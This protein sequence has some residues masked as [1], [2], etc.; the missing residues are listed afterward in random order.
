MTKEKN[1]I[2]KKEN[3][4]KKKNA[5]KPLILLKFPSNINQLL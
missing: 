2:I 4:E 3:N 1:N 5:F